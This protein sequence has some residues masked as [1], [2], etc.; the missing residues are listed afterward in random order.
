[1]NI[2]ANSSLLAGK[3]LNES[4]NLEQEVRPTGSAKSTHS[5]PD[6]PNVGS[7]KPIAITLK[8]DIRVLS[9]I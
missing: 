7:I 2:F 9:S 1:M 8:Y 3:S 4:Q 6:T 5:I